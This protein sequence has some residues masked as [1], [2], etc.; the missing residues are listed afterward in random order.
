MRKLTMVLL[1]LVTIMTCGASN[2]KEKI[3]VNFYGVDFSQVNVIGAKETETQFIDAFERIN[4]LMISEPKKYNVEKF[5]N[6]AVL[7][8]NISPA[9]KQIDKLKN[10]ESFKDKKIPAFSVAEIIKNYPECEDNGF[11]IIAKTLNKEEGKGTYVAVLYDGKTKEIL[12][13]TL[14]TGS[15]GGFGLRNF[16]AKSL[17]YGMK[18]MD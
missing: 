17:Y 9:V 7:S 8:V 3:R 2:K 4:G 15:V 5:F 11:V 12:S 13:H 1:M 16:W 10:G 6:L 18:Y 14:F